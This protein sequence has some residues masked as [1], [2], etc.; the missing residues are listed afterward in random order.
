MVSAVQNLFSSNL[1][2][3]SSKDQKSW[4]PKQPEMM[5]NPVSPIYYVGIR[6]PLGFT[7]LCLVGVIRSARA[8]HVAVLEHQ[9]SRLLH[10]T[11]RECILQGLHPSDSWAE[12]TGWSSPIYSVYVGYN[13]PRSS[14]NI[15]GCHQRLPPW[16]RAARRCLFWWENRCGKL[17]LVCS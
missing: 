14:T 7:W 4:N 5:V 6:S 12:R 16:T 17:W 9:W 3:P 10:V 15:S 8:P 11:H 1:D 2:L 13:S